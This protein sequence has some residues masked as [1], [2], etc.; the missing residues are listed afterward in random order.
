MAT[1]TYRPIVHIP[2]E[3]GK[4]VSLGTYD[5]LIKLVGAQTGN[6]MSIGLVTM[7]PGANSPPLHAH[8]EAESLYI[9]SGEIEVRT[10]TE[11]GRE[12]YRAGPGAL[13]FTPPNT[14]HQFANVGSTVAQG[15]AIFQPSGIEHVF[16]ELPGVIGPDGPPIP[17]RLA[18]LQ[19]KYGI[20]Q[21]ID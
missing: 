8:P 20:Q 9:I 12:S 14:P 6:A 18:A 3:G 19:A 16:A 10:K 7:P 13:I 2:A 5:V 15:L 4:Q 17:D 1:Q 21:I 11:R